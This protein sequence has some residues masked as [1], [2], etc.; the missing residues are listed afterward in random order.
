M[1]IPKKGAGTD[2]TSAIDGGGP[3][4][5]VPEEGVTFG[6]GDDGDSSGGA[7][8]RLLDDGVNSS[9]NGAEGEVSSEGRNAPGIGISAGEDV[10]G[11]PPVDGTRGSDG[12]GSGFGV[13]SSPS[14][15]TS[16]MSNINKTFPIQYCACRTSCQPSS[17]SR[18]ILVH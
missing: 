11:D 5:G 8:V 16:I 14:W 13:L 18:V 1:E 17:H 2:G 9:G 7:V 4:M 10:G 6:E 12:K 15:L 3:V